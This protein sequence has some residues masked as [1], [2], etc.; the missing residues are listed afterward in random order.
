MAAQALSQQGFR[1]VEALTKVVEEGKGPSRLWAATILGEIG[2]FAL[3]AVPALQKMSR[4]MNPDV[5]RV[6][7]LALKKIEAEQK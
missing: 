5:R 3:D 2:S 7:L 4:D 6:A 1:A